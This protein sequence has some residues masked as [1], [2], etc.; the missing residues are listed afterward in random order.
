MGIEYRLRFT[1]PTPEEVAT[2]LSLL[3][4]ISGPGPDGIFEV[5][6]SQSEMPDATMRIERCG[7][8]YCYYGGA[9]R[10]MLGVFIERLVSRFGSVT[11]EDWE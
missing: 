3:P 6:V 8:Y 4:A 11:V 5:R 10:E 9:G 2:V 7:A 1:S